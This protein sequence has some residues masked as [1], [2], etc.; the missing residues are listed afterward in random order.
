M[1]VLFRMKSEPSPLFARLNWKKQR[2]P[3]LSGQ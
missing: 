3:A 1:S 2:H